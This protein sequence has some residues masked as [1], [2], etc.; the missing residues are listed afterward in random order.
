MRR[1]GYPF[2]AMATESRLR[3]G[4]Q[5]RPQDRHRE[6]LPPVPVCF[7]PAVRVIA[8][9]SGGRRDRTAHGA[10]LQAVQAHQR[11]GVAGSNANGHG[12]EA[13]TRSLLRELRRPK[14]A[15][16]HQH[17]RVSH[18]AGTARGREESE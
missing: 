16:T 8:A 17:A 9:R 1:C 7:S 4:A 12:D 14:A 6:E 5:S 11:E 13:F 10:H 18:D 3:A 2:D 15:E